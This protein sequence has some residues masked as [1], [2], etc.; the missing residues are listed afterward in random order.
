MANK[1]RNTCKYTYIYLCVLNCEIVIQMCLID[2]LKKT[3]FEKKTLFNYKY[4]LKLSIISLSNTAQGLE[5]RL[6]FSVC[7]S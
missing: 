3:C 4:R 5:N 7:N 2:R 1:K 6:N